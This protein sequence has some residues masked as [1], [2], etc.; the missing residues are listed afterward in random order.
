MQA[1]AIYIIVRVDEGQTE[2]NNLDHLLYTTVVVSPN[3]VE[4]PLRRC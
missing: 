4:C 3:S 1:L 2:Y